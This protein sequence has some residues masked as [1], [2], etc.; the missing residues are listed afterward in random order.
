[1]IV[2]P[3]AVITHFVVVFWVGNNAL[4]TLKTFDNI[5]WEIW[6]ITHFVAV[7]CVGRSAPNT[8]LVL[9]TI[10]GKNYGWTHSLWRSYVWKLNALNA[11]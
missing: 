5:F 1:M 7:I 8:L 2:C 3:A 6:M 10:S 9:I 11:W 4:E